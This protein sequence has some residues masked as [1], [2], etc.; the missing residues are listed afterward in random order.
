[1]F[2]KFASMATN[3][4]SRS[5]LLHYGG[6]T[7]AS[8]SGNFCEKVP[9]RTF[10][11]FSSQSVQTALCWSTPR[12]LSRTM[13]TSLS[14]QYNKTAWLWSTLRNDGAGIGTLSWRQCARMLG[15]EQGDHTDSRTSQWFHGGSIQS[16][17]QVRTSSRV[18]GR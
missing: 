14:Q 10:Q 18:T 15:R 3:I 6:T 4:S 12:Q 16:Q 2:C 8:Q 11:L 17:V 1:M 13:R 9:A 7:S 5:H